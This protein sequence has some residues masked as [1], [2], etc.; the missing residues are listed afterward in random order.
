MA[1]ALCAVCERELITIHKGSNR[2]MIVCPANHVR[3]PAISTV[4]GSRQY[5][6]SE[7]QAIEEAARLYELMSSSHKEA[8]RLR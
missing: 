4:P 8:R 7:S 2:W 6:E 5:Y 1:K 3:L